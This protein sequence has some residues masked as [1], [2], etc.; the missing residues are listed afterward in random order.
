LDPLDGKKTREPQLFSEFL[1][2][3]VEAEWLVRFPGY[4]MM[5]LVTESE[6][7]QVLPY[8]SSELRAFFETYRDIPLIAFHSVV[9]PHTL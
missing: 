6:L 9:S 5:N 7:Q 3:D 2:E 1:A 8:F 4:S